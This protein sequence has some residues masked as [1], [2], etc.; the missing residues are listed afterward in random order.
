MDRGTVF[1]LCAGT[2]LAVA[3]IELILRR[4]WSRFVI[5]IVVFLVV[6]V[7]ALL[8]NNAAMG[9]VAFGE[10]TS[11][12]GTV[13]IMLLAIILGIAAR[14]LFYLEKGRFS[15]LDFVK[16]AAISPI[17]LLPLIGSV[18]A[19]STLSEMQVV[20]FA[21]LAFQNGFFWQAVLDG[22]KPIAHSAPDKGIR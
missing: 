4:R 18:Q 11:P 9:H 21:V 12:V 5:E 2:F 14:Y 20:S 13:G 1:E 3:I 19:S 10:G 7:I 17:V 15:W 6:T 8:V 22:S 16:P